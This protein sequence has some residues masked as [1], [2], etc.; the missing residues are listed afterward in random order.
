MGD[1]SPEKAGVGG[2]TPSLATMFQGLPW[3]EPCFLLPIAANSVRC[4]DCCMSGASC[5]VS[6]GNRGRNST[7]HDSLSG[8]GNGT[9]CLREDS[10]RI[11][12]DE[13]DCADD[14]YHE[15]TQNPR[16][17]LFD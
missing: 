6:V 7:V 8:T 17:F 2:S 14:G 4:S 16:D 5:C 1:Y 15:G 9:G 10:T 13:S 11:E 3:F 12:A